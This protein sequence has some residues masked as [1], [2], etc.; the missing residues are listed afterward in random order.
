MRMMSAHD[1]CNRI[2]HIVD[3]FDAERDIRKLLQSN[4]HAAFISVWLKHIFYDLH[5]TLLDQCELL[6]C[7]YSNAPPFC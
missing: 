7:I 4:E 6:S 5:R 2:I 1:P 3:A